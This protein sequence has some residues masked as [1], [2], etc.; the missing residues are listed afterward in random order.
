MKLKKIELTNFRSFE[1][2]EIEFND[3]L[4]V[5]VA[6]NGG[7]K[8]SVLDAVAIALSPFVGGFDSGINKGF[9]RTDARLKIIDSDNSTI[10]KEMES[11]YPITVQ[12]NAFIKNREYRWNRALNNNKK[13][14]KT[15]VKNSK[16]IR[17]YAKD[18]QNLVRSDNLDSV[19]LP[20]ISFYG[21][22]RLWNSKTFTNK[23]K[24]ESTDTQSRLWGYNRALEHA[25]T[26]KAFNDWFIAE[27]KA[28]YDKLIETI[29]LQ[30]RVENFQI[31]ESVALKNIRE[32]VNSSLEISGWNNL[33]YNSKFNAITVNHVEQGTMPVSR[34]SDGVRS[35][36]AMTADIAYRCTKLNPHLPNAPKETMGIILIDEVDLH[37]HPR[38]QQVVIPNLQKAFPNIQFIVTTHS[39]QVLTT[40]SKE[41]I[42]IIKHDEIWRGEE[43]TI[44]PFARESADA[45]AYVM[46]TNLKPPLKIIEKI[47]AYEIFV[48]NGK[49]E[50]TEAQQIK[51]ELDNIGYEIPEVDLE[52]WKF[53][54]EQNNG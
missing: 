13:G 1:K 49:I 7:G 17:D 29:Q 14:S 26:Y 39:P 4:T 12:A 18:L 48:K 45:L 41:H 32:A 46:N 10:I 16:S 42:R 36:L 33:R 9:K 40:V 30:N 43:P 19:I 22:E 28:E 38:W 3:N 27:S 54:A 21:T 50:S 52:L 35:I 51:T 2:F 20:I 34:L 6:E 47:H 53:L 15:T 23:Q 11:S 24:S 8:T 44:S 37:L 25:S 31:E 5:I